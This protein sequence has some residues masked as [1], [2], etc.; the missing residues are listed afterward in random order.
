MC[1]FDALRIK[2]EQCKKSLTYKRYVLI[3]VSGVF[4]LIWLVLLFFIHRVRKNI[5]IYEGKIKGS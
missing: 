5:L 4:F 2:L 3:I 1:P